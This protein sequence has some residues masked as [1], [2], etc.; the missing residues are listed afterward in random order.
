MR[1]LA[2][3]LLFVGLTFAGSMP[4]YAQRMGTPAYEQSSARASKHQQKMMR[5]AAKRQKKILKKTQKA[6][7]KSLKAAR[8]AD[9]KANR[10]FH[11]IPQ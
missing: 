8:K 3:F 11:R 9:A 6:Q 4:A 10:N 7:N 2:V 1:R 5:K